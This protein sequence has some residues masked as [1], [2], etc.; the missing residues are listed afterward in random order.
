MHGGAADSAH[1]SNLTLPYM[2]PLLSL[3]QGHTAWTLSRDDL[4]IFVHGGAADSAYFSDIYVLHT[5]Y[6]KWALV[7][8]YHKPAARAYHSMHMVRGGVFIFFGGRAG[9]IE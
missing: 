1:F 8:T 5:G 7:K 3:A 6:R 9:L 4:R 2:P